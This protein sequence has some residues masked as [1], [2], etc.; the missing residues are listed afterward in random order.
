MN[1]FQ[2]VAVSCII[3]LS[4]IAFSSA[5]TAQAKQC[6]AERPSNARLHWS[7][8][9][10]DGRRCW[11]EGKPMLSKSLL[12]WP[13]Q[14]AKADSKQEQNSPLANSHIQDAQASMPDDSDNFE[15][16]WRQRFLEAIGK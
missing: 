8:R 16:R 9:V 13:A 11:Y 7:Y 5:V 6:S 14:T 12:R 4:P 2:L 3:G 15:S 10:I 1:R